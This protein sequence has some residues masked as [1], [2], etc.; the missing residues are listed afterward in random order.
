MIQNAAAGNHFP[1]AGNFIPIKL[2]I[3]NYSYPIIIN[4]I[5]WISYHSYNIRSK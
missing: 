3:S 5:L 4:I 2:L 1:A